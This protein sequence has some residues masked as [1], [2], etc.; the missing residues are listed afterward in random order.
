MSILITGTSSGIGL[1]TAEKFLALGHTVWG[2][3]LCPSALEHPQYRHV[4]ADIRDDGSP[5]LAPIPAPEIL[6]NNAGTLEERLAAL[7]AE[8][9]SLIE[10]LLAG[11][12]PGAKRLPSRELFDL[13][14]AD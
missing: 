13:A 10:A 14:G 6:I 9:L 7:P 12:D 8:R 2:V 5:A 11:Q 1:A 3:D 4:Q